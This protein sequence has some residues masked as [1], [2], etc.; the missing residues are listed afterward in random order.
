MQ[1]DETTE[2]QLKVLVGA[3]VLALLLLA[4]LPGLRRRRTRTWLY[5]LAGLLGIAVYSDFG[6]FHSGRYLKY[7]EMFHYFLGSKY[8]PELGHDGLYV[9]SVAAQRQRD[10]AFP[11]K[12]VIRDLR[13]KRGI[14]TQAAEPHLREVV[15]RFEPARWASFVEDHHFFVLRF[16]RFLA[17][18]RKDHG[19]NPPP[20]WTFVGRLFSARLPANLPVLSSLAA[21]DV[22]LLAGLFHVVFRTYGPR[23]GSWSLAVFCLGY[24]WRFYYTGGAFLRMDWLA[25]LAI[26]LCMLERRRPAIAGALFGYAASVR[27]FPALLLLGPFVVA[28][29]HLVR[30]ESTG[31][32]LRLFGAFAA[33]VALAFVAGGLTGRGLAAWTEFA[34]AIAL[35]RETSP[36]NR[37]GLDNVLLNLPHMLANGLEDDVLPRLEPGELSAFSPA[38]LAGKVALLLLLAAAMWRSSPVR[39]AVLGMA[40]NFVLTPLG[41]YYW[42]MLL[43]LPLAGATGPAQAVVA[44]SVGLHAVHLAYADPYL[45][46]ALLSTGLAILLLLWILPDALRT[47]ARG[48]RRHA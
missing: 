8:F 38:R 19:Y 40:A 31:W 18:A 37:V 7:H 12:G 27:V 2:F 32:A 28:L 23:V 47:L 36:P 20:P 26:G 16:H 14:S 3:L 25:A 17:A 35:H 4:E 30:G 11:V 24:G 22:L 33:M 42:A 6:S 21:L 5:V 43:A 9:A 15:G 29:R 41:C 13:T 46:F 44:L 48:V 10:A 45:R 34:A 1:L 39:G